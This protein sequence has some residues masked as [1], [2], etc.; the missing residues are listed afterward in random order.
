MLKTIGIHEGRTEIQ[1]H[2]I[3][4]G[5]RSTFRQK[6]LSAQVRMH[7]HTLFMYFHLLDIIP[8]ASLRVESSQSF[9]PRHHIFV[10]L[11]TWEMWLFLLYRT[12]YVLP[13]IFR[14]LN[15]SSSR[16]QVPLGHILFSYKPHYASLHLALKLAESNNSNKI[17]FSLGKEITTT[18]IKNH[19]EAREK[20]CLIHTFQISS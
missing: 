18:I 10:K 15:T 17:E 14:Y 11:P 9:H 6:S 5:I 13:F 7:L 16:W 19:I 2:G 20:L 12:Y 8:L 3:I 4:V 1:I